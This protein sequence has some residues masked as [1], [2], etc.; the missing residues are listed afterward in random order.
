MQKP[1]T[2]L[3]ASV[4]A[5]VLIGVATTTGIAQSQTETTN[6]TGAAQQ[7]VSISETHFTLNGSMWI[8]RGVQ[9]RGFIAPT[10]YE[11]TQKDQDD[12]NAQINYGTNELNAAKSFGADELRFQ[13]SQYY[14]DRQSPKYDS[15]YVTTVQN[16]ITAARSTGFVVIISMQ[17]QPRS[18]DL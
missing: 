8:P 13:V 1:F 3:N 16:A 17:D 14:L 10:S 6:A 4:A 9:I 18:G 7:V 11:Q 5:T 12:Y 2:F 15:K